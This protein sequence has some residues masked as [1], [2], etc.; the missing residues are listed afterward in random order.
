M[1]FLTRASLF[2]CIN[3]CL[4]ST[5]LLSYMK[6]YLLGFD[7]GMCHISVYFICTQIHF[8]FYIV[9]CEE[10]GV[11]RWGVR[12]RTGRFTCRYVLNWYLRC[13]YFFHLLLLLLH[14]FIP[15]LTSPGLHLQI[16]V[17]VCVSLRI[18]KIE[19]R[20]M[21]ANT[22]FMTHAI[23]TTHSSECVWVCTV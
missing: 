17:Y 15:S 12:N 23:D 5:C 10:T 16:C 20:L 8:T 6:Y 4:V 9:N 22:V 2:K 18:E 14:L 1:T 21:A 19:H 7:I 13:C 11:A 3:Y